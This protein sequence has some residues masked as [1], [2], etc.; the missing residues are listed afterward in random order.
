[1]SDDDLLKHRIQPRQIDYYLVTETE[2][3][4]LRANT[5]IGDIL[6]AAASIVIG[7]ALSKEISGGFYVVG[8]IFFAVSMYFYWARFKLFRKV[9]QL[10]PTGSRSNQDTK[11]VSAH[12]GANDSWIDISDRVALALTAGGVTQVSNGLAGQD[13]L[14]NVPKYLRIKYLVDGELFEKV[15]PEG[16]LVELPPGIR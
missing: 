8:A 12:Y 13:P 1:V 14:P 9:Q 16:T 6:F 3:T 2:I 11:M 15:F 7:A 10:G 4:S 5:I